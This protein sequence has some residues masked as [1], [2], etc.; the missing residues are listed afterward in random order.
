[1]IHRIIVIDDQ[2]VELTDIEFRT[3]CMSN[4]T[5]AYPTA[6]INFKINGVKLY[7]HISEHGI[8]RFSRLNQLFDTNIARCILN[9]LREV[10]KS[11]FNYDFHLFRESVKNWQ[12]S[13]YGG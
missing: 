3:S 1:M 10:L 9:A 4:T 2:Y 11:E 6:W 13:S 5:S 12:V 8:C 7:E